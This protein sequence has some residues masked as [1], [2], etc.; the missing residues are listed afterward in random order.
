MTR[1]LIRY[2]SGRLATAVLLLAALSLV[3]YVGVDLLPGDPVTARL[4][5]NSTP[6]QVATARE[7]LGLDEP[8]ARRYLE[9]AGGLLHGNLGMSATGTP[10]ADMLAG[11]LGNTA[12]LAG[13]TL[14]LLVPLSLVLGIALGRRAGG[15]TDRTGSTVLLL[16]TAVPEFVVAA[17]LALLVGAQLGW[18]PATSL[19]PS[20]DS[21]LAHPDVLVLPVLSLLWVSLAYATRVVRAQALVAS[22]APHVEAMR[23]NGFPERVVLRHGVLP[24]VLPSAAQIWLITSA[25]LLGGTVLVESVFGYPGIGTVLVSS[26]STG[27]LPVV[28]ALAMLMGGLTLLATIAADLVGAAV[29]RTGSV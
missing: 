15:R 16:T 1:G 6:D 21:P 20:G 22:R 26:V 18:L 29:G 8:L 7:R 5:A 11:R 19:V 25:G 17:M 12:V 10:V 4:G 3:V 13:L 14:L 28:Q 24:A 9:W 2:A 27:D 23:L